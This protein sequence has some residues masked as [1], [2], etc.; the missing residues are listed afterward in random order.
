MGPLGIEIVTVVQPYAARTPSLCPGGSSTIQGG[1]GHLG[2]IPED[3]PE[4]RR[5][6][7]RGCGC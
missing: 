5:H 7:H 2:V 6:G 3:A 4:L 1:V